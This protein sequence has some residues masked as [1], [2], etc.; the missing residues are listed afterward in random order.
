MQGYWLKNQ[1]KPRCILFMAGWG[2][3]PE[4]FFSLDVDGCDLFMCYDYRKLSMPDMTMFSGYDRLE[5]IA[6]SMGV[7][8][9]AALFSGQEKLFSRATAVGGTLGPIDDKT[10]IPAAAFDATIEN[11]DGAGQEAFYASMFDVQMQSEKFMD[12]RPARSLSSVREELISLKEAV[13][14]TGSGPDIFSRR[15]VTMRDRVFPARNQLRAWG[16]ARAERVKWPHFPFYLDE[17]RSILLLPP[18]QK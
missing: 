8:V 6:W 11:L 4:P 18:E 15:I 12:N 16:K 9:A 7:W 10:G 13:E 14:R 17:C 1:K 2:M 3:G 5:L